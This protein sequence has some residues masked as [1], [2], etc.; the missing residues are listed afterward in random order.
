MS[1]TMAMRESKP[2]ITSSRMSKA[3]REIASQPINSHGD[4][5]RAAADE[6]DR[7]R[8]A[9]FWC[10]GCPCYGPEGRGHEG[11]K[12]IVA[13]LLSPDPQGS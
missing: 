3:L 7:L 1:A 11:W 9:L 8:D 12:K 4:L 13:P 6:I 2:S 10:S 5:I